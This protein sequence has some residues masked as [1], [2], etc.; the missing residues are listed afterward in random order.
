MIAT[1]ERLYEA[2]MDGL[3]TAINGAIVDLTYALY[4]AGKNLE[5]I[6]SSEDTTLYLHTNGSWA[7]EGSDEKASVLRADVNLTKVVAEY[8][9]TQPEWVDMEFSEQTAEIQK[10]MLL[11]FLKDIT[12]TKTRVDSKNANA[13]FRPR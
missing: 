10:A 13:R 2:D 7:L 5:Y 6:A 12:M 1:P 11:R 8:L 4:D 3:K 9:R